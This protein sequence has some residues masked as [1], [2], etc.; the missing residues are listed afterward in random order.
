MCLE[1]WVDQPSSLLMVRRDNRWWSE[2]EGES[3]VCLLWPG[4][5]IQQS[6]NSMGGEAL[7]IQNVGRNYPSRRFFPSSFEGS[8]KFFLFSF[9]FISSC[10]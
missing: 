1:F 7:L 4:S 6:Q 5:G 10:F 8:Q 9:G 2:G 3:S